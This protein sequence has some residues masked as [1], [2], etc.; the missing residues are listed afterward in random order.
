M[1]WE[2]CR[3]TATRSEIAACE[4]QPCRALDRHAQFSHHRSG[5]G[6]AEAP[7]VPGEPARFPWIDTA[8]CMSTSIHERGRSPA[9][10][11]RPG[12]EGGD[13][14]RSIASDAQP[15]P[16]AEA[17]AQH[18]LE[19]SPAARVQGTSIKRIAR[20]PENR[21]RLH[22]LRVELAKI[23]PLASNPE[24]ARVEIVKAM[25]RALLS[26]WTLPGLTD[27]MAAPCGAGSIRIQLLAHVIVF[28]PW[29]AFRIIDMHSPQVPFFE[30]RGRG[31]RSFS[32][33]P[34]D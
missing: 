31:G 11:L 13:A 2:A 20:G 18:G 1:Q 19:P 3:A 7:P 21:Q 6:N 28:N 22:R 17:L 33:V 16:S 30:L 34:L 27:P 4:G 15:A 26:G 10:T 32:P 9:L 23:D 8:P 5:G 29:G 12:G 14:S 25:A 24:E